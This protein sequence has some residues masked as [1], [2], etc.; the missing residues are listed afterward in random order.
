M[1]QIP[2][3]PLVDKNGDLR[4]WTEV[5][6]YVSRF[7]N[8]SYPRVDEDIREESVATAIVQLLTYWQYLASSSTEGEL[9]FGYALLYGTHKAKEWI[10]T[11]LQRRNREV[12]GFFNGGVAD[13]DD[14]REFDIP[15]DGPSVEDEVLERE[16][17]G[18]A[19]E[20][21]AA[22]PPE[23]LEDFFHNL[24]TPLTE[25]EQAE[26]EGVGRNA[27]HERRVVRRNKARRLAIERGI[28]D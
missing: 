24:L 22:L 1:Q 25:R 26:K 14:G 12:V 13:E 17:H 19:R 10:R 7:V 9:T 16:L 15:V 28:L 8:V 4:S 6:S 18:Q 5:Q 27:I 21:L 20:L 3:A 23:E 11:E 2:E